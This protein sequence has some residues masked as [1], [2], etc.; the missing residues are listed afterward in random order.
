MARQKQVDD[1]LHRCLTGQPAVPHKL[2]AELCQGI[3]TLHHYHHTLLKYRLVDRRCLHEWWEKPTDKRIFEA[4]LAY[5]GS[6]PGDRL[7][8][9]THR[10]D[11]DDLEQLSVG[12]GTC[13]LAHGTKVK[14]IATEFQVHIAF[15]LHTEVMART[16]ALNIRQHNCAVTADYHAMAFVVPGTAF[17]LSEDDGLH[18]LGLKLLDVLI[19]EKT[20]RCAIFVSCWCQKPKVKNP[21]AHKMCDIA[22]QLVRRHVMKAAPC[23]AKKIGI[24]PTGSSSSNSSNLCVEKSNGEVQRRRE[25][26][27]AAAEA[28]LAASVADSC[29]REPGEQMKRKLSDLTPVSG[30]AGRGEELAKQRPLKVSRGFEVREPPTGSVDAP[31][32]ATVPKIEALANSTPLVGCK[33]FDCSFS[34]VDGLLD[35]D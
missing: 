12:S 26:R 31:R 20:T 21:T 35:L 19:R 4:A 27:A 32:S 11:S 30:L 6:L 29:W 3:L 5:L 1:C 34:A 17:R 28:R 8:Q 13:W 25:L 22:R 23:T 10:V 2:R 24:M 16:A 18:G 33:A 7:T 9:D 14:E 15:P